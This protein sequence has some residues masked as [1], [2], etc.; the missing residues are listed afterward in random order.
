MAIISPLTY[1]IAN[2]QAVDATPLMADLNQIV[3]NVNA[4]AVASASLAA[5]G[6]AGLVG[7]SQG[8][9]GSVLRTQAEK[10]QESVS[11]LDFGA[12]PTGVADSTAAIQD[13]LNTGHL[14][15][16]PAGDYLVSSTLTK[17]SNY[18]GIVGAGFQSRIITNSATGDIFSI[19]NGTAQISG[20]IFRD[21]RVWSSVQKTSGAVFN[22]QQ[23]ARSVFENV[24]AGSLDD[25]TT[26]NNTNMLFDGYIFNQF[27]VIDII[28]GECVGWANNGFKVNG[29]PTG[30]FGA[31]IHIV[32]GTLI[33]GGTANTSKAVYLA[34][35]AGGVYLDC[36]VSLCGGY[37][38]YSD[39]SATSLTYP[40]R[41]LILGSTCTIDSCANWGVYIASDSI[42]LL[43]MNDSWIANCGNSV[44]S[45]GGI[46]CQPLVSGTVPEIKM[47][48]CQ[49]YSNYYD[50]IQLNNSS[51]TLTGC[52]VRNNG[53]GT[54]GGHGVN[55]PDVNTT[56][57]VINGCFIHN[58]GNATRG[59]GIS[60]TSGSQ[61]NFS[62][63]SNVLAA[64]AEGAIYNPAANSPSAIIRNNVGYV[65]ENMG[66]ASIPSGSTSV[67]VNH[68]LSATPSIAIPFLV[69]A[70]NVSGSIF[71][72]PSSFTATQLTITSTVAATTGGIPVG[73]R[74]TIGSQ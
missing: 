28:G 38:V 16:L 55:I 14:V 47:D 69:G 58:N 48:G 42:A 64:N 44:T 13:A 51:F 6:G 37:G 3:G 29:S 41:E 70:P 36:S 65:S 40:N 45:A 57:F 17:S 15:L 73:W 54:P 74:A 71:I 53:T 67:T 33:Q 9:S 26:S 30:T 60:I 35:G 1:T 2:G 27:S 8:A 32:A 12:D 5:S 52:I 72:A 61:T 20:L 59:Y 39:V 24:H 49:I 46:N 7:Y 56:P 21:F 25:Y 34:G 22:C 10:N 11:V 66:T 18:G 63:Q 68:G 19:G 50:G 31:E 43:E 4:N 62:I 23:I